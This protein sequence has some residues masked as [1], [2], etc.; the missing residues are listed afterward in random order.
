VIAFERRASTVLFNLVSGRRD[1]RPYLVPANGCP[2]LPITLLKAGAPFELVDISSSTLCMDTEAALERVRGKRG[3]YAGLIYVRTYGALTDVGQFFVEFKRVAPDTLIIDDRCLCPPEFPKFTP[4]GVDAVLYSTGYAKFVDL[5]WGGYG[6]IGEPI[7]YNSTRGSFDP[8]AL[9]RLTAQY[10][11]ALSAGTRFSYQDSPWLEQ[12]SPDLTWQEYESRVRT[13]RARIASG[14]SSMNAIYRSGLPPGLQLQEQFQN[15]RFNILVANVA[16][17]L[18]SISAAGLFASNH[19]AS[20]SGIFAEEKA[21]RARKLHQHVVN[22]FN[23]RYFDDTRAD[24]LVE[25]IRRVASPLEDHEIGK[26]ACGHGTLIS[27][28]PPRLVD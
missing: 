15:W 20:L 24:E 27:C 2:I 7:E 14:K 16:Q 5:G 11:A 18:A 21:P 25:I 13:E 6:V 12:G 8:Q 10:K 4:E 22:L 17:V 3:R 19:Y 28:L 23:D 9:D 1:E 26:F